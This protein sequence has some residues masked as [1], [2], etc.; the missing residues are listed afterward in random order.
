MENYVLSTDKLEIGYSARKAVHS[1]AKDIYI[2]LEKGRLTCLMGPNGVGKST[3][4]KTITGIL[5]PLSG[6]VRIEG[7]NF[8]QLNLSDRARLL[9]VVLTEKPIQGHMTVRDLISLGRYPYTNWHNMIKPEDNQQIEN[10]IS[11]VELKHQADTQLSELSDGNLQKA[12][13]GRALAQD[14]ELIILDEPTIHLDVNNKTI[15]IKLLKKLSS[16]SGKTILLSTHD[17]ELATQYADIL[18]LFSEKGII[19]GLPED[20]LIQGKIREV[21][22]ATEINSVDSDCRENIRVTGDPKI[23]ELIQLALCKAQLY[24]KLMLNDI[25]KVEQ[26]NNKIKISYQNEEFDSINSLIVHL[27]EHY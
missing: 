4:I 15:I 14:T 23:A 27:S 26:H 18:W 22:T 9:S 3:L 20:L 8:Y 21:F 5:P 19:N 12:I 10:A 1:V 6:E 24:G 25:I 17:L 11:A 16:E 2:K 7:K 13:I